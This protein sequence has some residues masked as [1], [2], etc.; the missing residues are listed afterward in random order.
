MA[1]ALNGSHSSS[2]R[3]CVNASASSLDGGLG[4]KQSRRRHGLISSISVRSFL[5][6]APLMHGLNVIG[7][8]VSAGATHAARVDVVRDDIV[9]I[10]EVLSAD[11]T[12]AVL[13]P[14]LMIKQFAYFSLRAQFPIS[15]EMLGILDASHANV[16]R[17]LLH[18]LSAAAETRS[19]DGTELITT[20]SRRLFLENLVCG[21]VSF[22]N[23]TTV[24]PRLAVRKYRLSKS[25]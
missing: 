15:A 3:G 11:T 8:I 6:V 23:L 9:V 25:L 2:G 24:P 18:I 19:V 16:T 7:M 1:N 13:V 22:R 21:G 5:S 17:S 20:D 12:F 10:S 4:K 14:N